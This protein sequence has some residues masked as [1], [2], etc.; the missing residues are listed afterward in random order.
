MKKIIAL[1]LTLVTVLSLTF[2]VPASAAESRTVTGIQVVEK[3]FKK[4]TYA[5]SI[6]ADSSIS[7]AIYTTKEDAQNDS[8][9]NT[10][11]STY[12]Y[13]DAGETKNSFFN[14]E[15]TG[16]YFVLYK[17][18]TTYVDGDNVFLPTNVTEKYTYYPIGGTLKLG[19]AFFGTSLGDGKTVAYYKVNV[20]KTGYLDVT[21][22]SQG[23]Y[24]LWSHK[25]RIMNSKK[26]SI[27][28][29]WDYIY[30]DSRN[31]KGIGV[32][33][34]TY[35]IAVLSSY[36]SENYY[37]I[38]A[39]FTKRGLGGKAKKS[40]AVK[41]KKNKAVKGVVLQSGSTA[42]YKINNT[43][44]KKI[45]IIINGQTFSG[46]DYGGITI[47]AYEGKKSIGKS[48]FSSETKKSSNKYY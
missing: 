48:Y 5:W 37:S 17:P 24:Y 29:N 42:W 31:S 43:K 16:T 32:K 12:Y 22:K 27:S 13:L 8:F 19:K 20:K 28:G 38:T 25:V 41:L 21:I 23:S 39:K 15:K 14:I 2:A 44:N 45:T 3:V 10:V 11:S 40:K 1:T 7:G 35:Y 4:G 47:E 34:G 9:A 6:S 46:G 33:K 26:K 36:S 18:S 30:D